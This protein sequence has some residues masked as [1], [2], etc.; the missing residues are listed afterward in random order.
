MW[1]LITH[2]WVEWLCGVIGAGIIGFVKFGFPKLRALWNAVL[3]LLHDRIYGECYRFLD[4]GYITR[5]GMR[6]LTY[7][8]SA[9][10]ALGGNGTGTELYNRAKSLPLKEA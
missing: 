4:L 1:E 5:D 6:N 10:H 3:A 8:Y 9:Y 7:L 2:Y